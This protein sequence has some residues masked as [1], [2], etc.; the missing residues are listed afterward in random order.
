MRMSRTDIFTL[1]LF[2]VLTTLFIASV[3]FETSERLKV[4]KVQHWN[5]E[6][7]ST[8]NPY[9]AIRVE[10]TVPMKILLFGIALLV[11]VG[12]VLSSIPPECL[13]RQITMDDISSMKVMKERLDV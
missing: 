13:R 12:A 7:D 2:G 3:Y 10:I 5:E 9:Y 11:F 8:H 1:I 4:D 6:E